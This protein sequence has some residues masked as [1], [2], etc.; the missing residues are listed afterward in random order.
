[1]FPSAIDLTWFGK[2]CKEI[3]CSEGI[4]KSLFRFLSIVLLLFSDRSFWEE[5][6]ANVKWES[7]SVKSV[8]SESYTDIFYSETNDAEQHR[9]VIISITT[10]FAELLSF[11]SLCS[12]SVAVLSDLLSSVF[13]QLQLECNNYNDKQQQWCP[14][15][16]PTPGNQVFPVFIPWYVN[17]QKEDKYFLCLFFLIEITSE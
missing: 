14:L 4:L 17:G 8:V 7:C 6:K 13:I 1:M 3:I 9:L 15:L 5:V 2:F 12:F 16:G 10:E 11:L